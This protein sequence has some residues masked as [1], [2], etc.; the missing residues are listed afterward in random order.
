VTVALFRLGS[1][2]DSTTIVRGG[3]VYMRPAEMRDFDEWAA[4]RERSRT[5][6]SIWEPVWP[7]DDL[8][9]AAFRRRIRLHAEEMNR[10]E[11]FPF[12][13]FRDDDT[14]LGGLTVGQIRRG[15]AQTGTLGYWMGEPYAGRGYMSAAV[16]AVT[17]FVF[18]TLRLHR[19]EAACLPHNKASM[20]LLESVGFQREGYARSYLRING[21]WQDHI[22]FA[23]IES[24]PV[25]PGRRDEA[26]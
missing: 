10:D 1:T 14:M 16:R 13:V 19:L 21:R 9:R 20:H 18:S 11:A 26:R 7:A 25:L 8:T 5:F 24:D 12:L 3:G 2:H 17:N 23:M 4:L 15:V 6:L 22:L